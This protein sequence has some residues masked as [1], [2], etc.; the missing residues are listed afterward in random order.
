MPLD[1]THET[2]ELAA[3][4]AVAA[5]LGLGLAWAP[6]RGAVRRLADRLAELSPLRFGLLLF[7]LTVGLRLTGIPLFEQRY[8]F[9]VREYVEKA[10]LL[11]D[12]GSVHAQEWQGWMPQGPK[13]FYRTLGYSL[14]LA[15]WFLTTG[16]R[17][18]LAAQVFNV[19][20]SGLT[21]LGIARIGDDVAGRGVGRLAALGFAVYL[22]HWIFPLHAYAETFA[23]ALLVG[24]AVA[25]RIAV[26][27]DRSR[28]ARSV[29]AVLLGLALGWL[30]ITR[31]ELLWLPPLALAGLAWVR[32]RSSGLREGAALVVLVIAGLAMPLVANHT[33]RSGYPGT[34][35][36]SVQG[37]LILYFGN[38][39]IEVTGH[40]NATPRVGEE[41]RRLYIEAPDGSAARDAALTWMRENPDQ[42]LLNA[43]KKLYFL[44]LAAPEGFGWRAQ[45]GQPGGMHPRLGWFLMHVAHVQSLLVLVLG[46]WGLV[47]LRRR[48]WPWL[49]V[50]GLHAG[51]FA[52]LAPVPRNRLPFEPFVLVGVAVWLVGRRSETDEAHA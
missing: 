26:D 1:W 21:A 22:P 38:N 6:V 20:L 23:T 3:H 28:V 52:L 27:R 14:A 15:L 33:V 31:T 16:T 34:L 39:P 48:V 40:G 18:L 29:A 5:L 8:H 11:A 51:M 43:P 25:A 12:T 24:A 30:V 10:Q 46:L 47:R 19:L 41:L 32:Y 4:L 7:A 13:Y 49:L 35:R 17:S 42:V 44:W 9:D 45:T 50:I 37:G 2:L 36:T